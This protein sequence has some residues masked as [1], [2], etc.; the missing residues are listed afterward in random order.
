MPSF[1]LKMAS[2]ESKNGSPS[3][4][5]SVVS[6]SKLHFSAQED[7]IANPQIAVAAEDRSEGRV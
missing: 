3:A 4:S 6:R 7:Q 1:M 2:Y 5:V